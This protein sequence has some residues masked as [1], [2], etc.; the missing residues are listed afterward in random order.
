MMCVYFVNVCGSHWRNN[1]NRAF[2]DTFLSFKKYILGIL[3]LLFH[4]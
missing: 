3:L 1:E 2:A 4:V